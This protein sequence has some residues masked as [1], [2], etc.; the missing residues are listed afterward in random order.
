MCEEGQ[1]DMKNASKTYWLPPYI[2]LTVLLEDLQGPRLPGLVKGFF[3]PPQGDTQTLNQKIGK[4]LTA[5]NLWKKR[6]S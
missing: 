4:I 6:K 1:K 5:I 2:C 3:L